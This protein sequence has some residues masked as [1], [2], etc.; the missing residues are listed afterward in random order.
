[1]NRVSQ[2]LAPAKLNL[3]LYIT[4]QRC[5]GY[6][7][8]Q[9]V[10]VLLD[11]YDE[12]DFTLRDDKE[13][14]RIGGL[15]DVADDDDLVIRAAKLLKH[16][17]EATLDRPVQGVTI[18]LQKNIPAGAGLGG[19][20]SDAATTLLALNQLWNCQLNVSQLA[21][22]GLQLGADVPVFVYQQHAFAEGVG[23]Q[24]Q[25]LN[26]QIQ[27]QMPPAYVVITPAAHVC[28]QT[29]FQ[30][31]NLPRQTPRR[32]LDILISLP[33]YH[34]HNDCESVVAQHYPDVAQALALLREYGPAQMTGTGAS[35]FLPC[36]N[37]DEAAAI[38][39]QLRPRLPSD[40]KNWALRALSPSTN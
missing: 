14:E 8:L 35:V 34:S 2:H 21:T 4:G 40:W 18:S 3:F 37:L 39:Q 5:N 1:M 20:S 32:S 6:H 31:P 7:E 30:H 10:F 24:L 19:G 36:S 23:E 25:P 22:L 33:A 28:T 15:T 16:T 38:Q 29:V 12:L 13:I 26:P 11:L 9:T 17:A 27:A